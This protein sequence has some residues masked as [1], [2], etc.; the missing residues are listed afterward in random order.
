M[1]HVGVNVSEILPK[2]CY[3]V[4]AGYYIYIT[5]CSIIIADFI[6]SQAQR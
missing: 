2:T 6:K 1:I 3:V 4:L 5:F